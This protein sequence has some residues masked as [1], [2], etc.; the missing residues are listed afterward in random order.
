MKDVHNTAARSDAI[1]RFAQQRRREELKKDPSAPS[2]VD[3]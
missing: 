1:K 2:G 3:Q